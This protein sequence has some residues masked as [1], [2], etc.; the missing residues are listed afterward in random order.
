MR[1]KVIFVVFAL[2]FLFPFPVSASMVTVK[3]NGQIVVNVLGLT[4]SQMLTTPTPKDIEVS[5]LYEG[6]DS[7]IK[8]T[9]IDNKISLNLGNGESFDVT[10]IKDSLVEIEEKPKSKAVRVTVEDSNFILE[11]EGL[12]TKTAY[13]IHISAVSN[14]FSL[15][16]PTGEKFLKV[17]PYEALQSAYRAKVMS[18]LTKDSFNLTEVDSDLAYE[19]K[20]I[21][22]VNLFNIMNLDVPV[23]VQVSASTGEIKYIDQPKWLTVLN[24]LFV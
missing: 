3:E 6:G 23:M 14:T 10:N 2:M 19:I 18:S 7:E 9:N 22:V 12:I 21:R 1:Y 15:T 4:T 16:T 8:L 11:Q 13:P 5:R 20:G 17:F 24:F